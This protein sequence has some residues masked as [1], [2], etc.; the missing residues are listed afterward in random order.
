MGGLAMNATPQQR[1]QIEA[2]QGFLLL[3]MAEHAQRELAGIP[4]GE[5]DGTWH[6]LQAEACRLLGDHEA[7]VL[8]YRRALADDPQ[9]LE[10]LNGLAWCLKRTERLPAAISAMLQAYGAHPKEA[11]V[12][13]NLACYYALAGDKTQALSWLGRALRMQPALNRLIPE[14]ADFAGLRSDPDFQ[15]I[16]Q[17]TAAAEQAERNR[18]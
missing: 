9:N 1:R 3:E 6:G 10:L 5:R 17:T 16:V 7:A 8:E 11:S 13:Y 12:L 4:A 2:A 14:D 15:F 18:A